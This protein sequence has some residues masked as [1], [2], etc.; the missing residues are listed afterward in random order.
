MVHPRRHLTASPAKGRRE[1]I[2][3]ET[4]EWRTYPLSENSDTMARVPDEE[5][6]LPFRRLATTWTAIAVFSK[7]H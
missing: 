2:H 4:T 5:W 6:S 1:R 7:Q 3:S